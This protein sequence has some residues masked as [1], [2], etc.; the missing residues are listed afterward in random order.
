MRGNI[1]GV[2]SAKLFWLEDIVSF[3][4]TLKHFFWKLTSVGSVQDW[5]LREKYVVYV[6]TCPDV[7]TIAPILTLIVVLHLS[8]SGKGLENCN[9]S[10]SPGDP[11]YLVNDWSPN[12]R[13]TL[14]EL[15][16]WGLFVNNF[17][18]RLILGRSVSQSSMP[19]ATRENHLKVF[20]FSHSPAFTS[21]RRQNRVVSKICIIVTAKLA[22][23]VYT[24][25]CLSIPYQ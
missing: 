14:R 22:D 3:L 18:W 1:P 5:G 4:S 16:Q 9:V 20:G 19:C 23:S 10:L 24:R 11:K 13:M 12:I 6:F 17:N 21:G 15:R 25:V 2:L 8:E 7:C